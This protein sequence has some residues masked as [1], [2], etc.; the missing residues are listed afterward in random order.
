MTSETIARSFAGM[1]ILE[2][3][4]VTL[5]NL[6]A[7]AT[8]DDLDWQPASERSS[9]SMVLAHLADVEAAGFMSRLTAIAEQDNPTLPVYDQLTLPIGDCHA[10]VSGLNLKTATDCTDRARQDLSFVIGYW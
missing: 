4:P 9:I 2:Q 8:R 1:P 5:K 6:L 3:T 7:K 10:V